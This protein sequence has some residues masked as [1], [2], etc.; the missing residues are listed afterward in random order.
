MEVTVHED[1]Q[2]RGLYFYDSTH[3]LLSSLRFFGADEGIPQV[4]PSTTSSLAFCD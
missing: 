4:S 2:E 1:P 3:A